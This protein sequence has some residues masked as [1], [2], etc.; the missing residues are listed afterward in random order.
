V[1]RSA[2]YVKWVNQCFFMK[3]TEDDRTKLEAESILKLKFFNAYD[4][5]DLEFCFFTKEGRVEIWC[6][7]LKTLGE[8]FQ[9]LVEYVGAKELNSEL[10][11]P[12][13]KEKL[14]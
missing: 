4:K 1:E 5:V 10:C 14:K 3:W 13:E 6:D 9:D 12:K 2:R 11:F 7:E 8:V